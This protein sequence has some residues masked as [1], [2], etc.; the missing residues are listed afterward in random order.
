MVYFEGI[1]FQIFKVEH[2]TIKI[3]KGRLSMRNLI[4]T[5]FEIKFF[6]I[7]DVFFLNFIC[8]TFQFLECS[9]F[10]KNI[11]VEYFRLCNLKCTLFWYF[12]ANL[13]LF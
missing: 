13:I 11:F 6:S 10:K 1:E 3:L 5:I 9:G 2:F 4:F 8:F 12:L 7:F